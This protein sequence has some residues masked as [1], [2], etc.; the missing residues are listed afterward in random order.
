MNKE[1]EGRERGK[2]RQDRERESIAVQGVKAGGGG[3]RMSVSDTSRHRNV[4]WFLLHTWVNKN[5]ISVDNSNP[6]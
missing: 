5:N 4:H 2:E 1:M 3:Y 6:I